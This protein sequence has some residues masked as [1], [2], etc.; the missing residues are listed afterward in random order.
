MCKELKGEIG[1]KIT[2]MT[3]APLRELRKQ[4]AKEE[5]AERK[6]EVDEFEEESN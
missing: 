5:S 6:L 3:G 1:S 4:I 2:P